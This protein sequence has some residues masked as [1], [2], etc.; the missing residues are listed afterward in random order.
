[1]KNFGRTL[2]ASSRSFEGIPGLLPSDGDGE[3]ST[4]TRFSM[5][6]TERSFRSGPTRQDGRTQFPQQNG[7]PHGCTDRPEERQYLS[8]TISFC[9]SIKKRRRKKKKKKEY[10]HLKDKQ[11]IFN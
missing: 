3:K 6:A 4:I 8:E 10:F 2:R 5:G 7:T 9:I 11:L 1:M